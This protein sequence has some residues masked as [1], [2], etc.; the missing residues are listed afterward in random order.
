MRWRVCS[1]KVAV[2]GILVL[3]S[4]AA[5]ATMEPVQAQAQSNEPNAFDQRWTL[6]GPFASWGLNSGFGA[7]DISRQAFTTPFASGI[8]GLFVEANTAGAGGP[9]GNLLG[10]AFP[11]SQGQNW[12][13]NFGNLD[14]KTSVFGS[15]KSD[16]KLFNGLYTTASFGI[17]DF[18]TNP[19]GYS[20]LP[21][22]SGGNDAVAVTAR[23]GLGLQITP[24]ITIEGSVGFT[25]M[26]SSAYGSAFR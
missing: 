11:T 16:P 15:Y 20:G 1:R 26:Q 3:A 5:M 25:Q 4:M 13:S 8:A 21:N 10:P 2:G 23:A 18:K 19:L 17:T 14:W 22:F 6:T 12:F 24:Q 9:Y 7:N